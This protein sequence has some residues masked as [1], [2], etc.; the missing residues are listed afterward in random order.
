MPLAPLTTFEIGGAA[1]YFVEVR[2]EDELKEALAWAHTMQ[3]EFAILGG[4]SNVL[5]ADEGFDGLI[6]KIASDEFSF[7]GMTLVTDAGCNLLTLVRA[8][9]QNN[10][11]FWE[12]LSGIPGTLG[13]AVRG[14]AGAFGTEIKDV[15][16][17]VQAFNTQ[18]GESKIFL[19]LSMDFS[20]RHS[21]FK[22]HPEWVIMRVHIDLARTTREESERLIAETIAEREKRHLQNVRA[23]GSYFMNPVAPQDVVDMFEKEKDVKAREGRVPAGWLIEKTGMKGLQIG[24]AQASP[25]HPNYLVNA[26]GSATAVDV[27]QLAEQIKAKVKSQFGVSLHEEAAIW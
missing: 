8:A 27:R 20:Y 2:G 23:A 1:L 18:T 14:N 19:N 6:I 15:V 12:K 11:G 25:Q 17:Q 3:Q 26:S 4:G 24:G 5:V 9:S 10:L 7:D 22:D 13:G 16:T 21:Y